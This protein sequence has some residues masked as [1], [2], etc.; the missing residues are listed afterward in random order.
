MKLH[1]ILQ[2]LTAIAVIIAFLSV[3]AALIFIEIPERNRETFIHLMGIIEG[4]FVTGLVG[5][6]FGSSKGSHDKTQAM[7]ESNKKF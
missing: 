3:V 4:S 5:Y 6:Y 2:T 7:I 1:D